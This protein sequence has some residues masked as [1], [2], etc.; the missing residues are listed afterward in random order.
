MNSIYAL[1]K[2]V[3][4]TSVTFNNNV[5]GTVLVDLKEPTKV[6]ITKE[7]YDYECGWRFHGEVQDKDV[8]AYL[9]EKGLVAKSE[10]YIE[11]YKQYKNN[12]NLYL[13]SKKAYDN[14]NPKVVYFSEYDI[15]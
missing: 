6:K 12:P 5:G 14:Y 2:I 7:W 10:E 4:V 1:G 11:S 9:Y 13:D 8:I 3:E 15:I